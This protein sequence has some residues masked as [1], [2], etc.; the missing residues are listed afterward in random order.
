MCRFNVVI[1]AKPIVIPSRRSR[2]RS[3]LLRAKRFLRCSASTWRM[4]AKAYAVKAEDN[5]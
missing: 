3:D 5:G 2:S 4:V 1:A